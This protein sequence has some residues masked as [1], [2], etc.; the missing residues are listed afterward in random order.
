[1]K[2]IPAIDLID[3]CCV[4]LQQGMFGS[5][6]I[7]AAD[8]LE[9]ALI[10]REAGFADLHLVDLDAVRGKNFQWQ[11][12]ERICKNTDLRV[13]FGGG[14]RTAE[15]VAQLFDIG[16]QE[17]SIGSM[18]VKTPDLF[19][20]LL[21]NWGADRITLSADVQDGK[22][23]ITGWEEDT[24]L[25]LYAFLDR[26]IKDGLKKTV[27]TDVA[28]DG[29]LQGASN[30]LYKKVKSAFPELAVIASGGVGSQADIEEVALAGV[31]GVIV[32]KAFYEGKI[33]IPGFQTEKVQS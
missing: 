17:I 13:D 26:W 10:F 8:P 19:L 5:K 11:V 20:T 33:P 6:K 29:M 9:M 27:I 23:Q 25:S 1:M 12:I 24:G 21:N 30:A 18:A 16:V 3:G 32:G 2:V 31:D 15:Q 28:R 4:R 14:V 7:Y 22:V